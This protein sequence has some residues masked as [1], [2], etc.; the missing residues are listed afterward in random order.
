MPHIPNHPPIAPKLA[1]LLSG[2]RRRIRSY[3][4][5]DGLA[6]LVVLLGAAFWASLALDWLFEP[7][8]PLRVGVL[9]AVAVAALWVAYRLI[10]SRAFVQ[11]ANR[12]LALVLERRFH[13]LRDSL[14]TV[15][16]LGEHDDPQHEFNPRM[17]AETEMEA[18]AGAGDVNVS[19]ALNFRPLLRRVA[20]A[21]LLLVSVVGFS[22]AARDAFGIWMRRSL[23]MS[24]EL[25]PRKT[26]LSVV[27]FADSP[28]KKIARGGDLELN[29][30]ADAAPGRVVPD[31][32]EVRYYSE[33]G[34]R[35]RENMSRLGSVVP[36]TDAFQPYVYT[37]KSVLT[38]V[39]FYVLGGDDRLGPYRLQVVDSPTINRMT[40]HCE[41]PAYMR[42]TP[43]DL[44]VT[45][46]MPIPRGTKV[47]L[48]AETNKDVEQVR[49][50]QL[51]N[52][53]TPSITELSLAGSETPRQFSL[54]LPALDSDVTLQFAL[55]DTDGIRSRDA[56]RLSLSLVEDEAPRVEARLAGIGTAIT[57]QARLPLDGEI[58]DDYSLG[59][60]WFEYTVDNN[61]SEQQP[62]AATLAGRDQVVANEVLE[63]GP[64]QLKP[65][66]RL[67]LL[68]QVAD[69]CDLSGDPNVGASQKYVLD[70]VTPGE[71]RSLLEARE[72]QLRRRFETI[73]Q[74]FTDT[75]DLL[76]RIDLV[77][78]P[79]GEKA[80]DAEKPAADG[81]SSADEPGD[82]PAALEEG[83]EPGDKA[84]TR[85]AVEV[86]PVAAATQRKVQSARCIQNS[87]RANDETR[88]LAVAFDEIRAEL[89]N[90][91]VD[92]EELKQRL[93]QG[94][95]DPLRRIADERFPELDRRL[96]QMDALIDRP[97]EAE[98]LQAASR[99]QADLILVEMQQVMDNLLELETF[100]EALD[101]LRNI[102]K[103][104]DELNEQTK[105]RRKAKLLELLEE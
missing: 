69:T 102:I 75:R 28:V 11:L 51:A 61:P 90:N 50:D 10:L 26:D 31:V 101:I 47:T 85:R 56:I 81:N 84:T 104:Q 48:R 29:V 49:I 27:E 46:I 80:P 59:R 39:E 52:G 54:E 21:G 42:R 86:D 34:G 88:G 79:A 89:I 76:A 3:V 71:L 65:K 14:L 24:E 2:L 92:T 100:N 95:A 73:L 5:I 8:V 23:L 20:L 44:P 99:Q 67:E 82:K 12:S 41:Y 22:L 83:A 62:F 103:T 18:L 105:E 36:G 66:Q 30:R 35:S 43:R 97:A 9:A 72:L 40:L 94:I 33:D 25:W 55:L 17:L 74:E 4:W 93:Q 91:R 98:R 68:A 32:V 7:P 45:G 13:G 87:A 78:K 70:I 16:E 38:D 96:K 63:V 58:T 1:E 64:L 60:G 15:V 53:D 19:A 77:A 6:A 57:P 37:F